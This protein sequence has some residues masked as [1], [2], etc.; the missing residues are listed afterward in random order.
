M[1]KTTIVHMTPYEI[2]TSGYL[3]VTEWGEN[4]IFK[5][6]PDPDFRGKLSAIEW[7][8]NDNV[9]HRI[10][11]EDD[12]FSL[13]R[14]VGERPEIEIDSSWLK[15][16][17]IPISVSSVLRIK[18]EFETFRHEPHWYAF[19][20]LVVAQGDMV[21]D[22]KAAYKIPKPTVSEIFEKEDD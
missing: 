6:Q 18:M 1:I 4:I 5:F 14:Q 13:F 11:S 2:T 19:L 8:V 20:N 16:L 12:E 3:K 17:D 10:S 22:S 21:H 9:K 15:T 7:N